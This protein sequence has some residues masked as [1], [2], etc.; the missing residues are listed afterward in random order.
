[1]C[2]YVYIYVNKCMYESKFP[3]PLAAS[4]QSTQVY[5]PGHM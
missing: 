1:M 3:P 4:S 2:M 5:E